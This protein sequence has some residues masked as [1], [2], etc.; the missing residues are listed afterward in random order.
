MEQE[1]IKSEDIIEGI[2]ID[3]F[4]CSLSRVE[5]QRDNI[6]SYYTVL[7][8]DVIDI[9]QLGGGVV[10]ICDDEGRLKTDNRWFK[11]GDT[12][13]CGRALLLN[14]IVDEDGMYTNTDIKLSEEQVLDKLKWLPEDFYEE[15]EIKFTG[16]TSEWCI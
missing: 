6:Q 14:T 5:V 2:L 10:M 4:D 1:I 11:L 7:D 8:C 12:N 15:P 13:Y 16:F 9:V 3:P